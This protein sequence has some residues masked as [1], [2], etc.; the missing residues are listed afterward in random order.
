M[1]AR[2]SPPSRSLRI[3]ILLGP[4]GGR[5]VSRLPPAALI[6]RMRKP[7]TGSLTKAQPVTH[8]CQAL[9]GLDR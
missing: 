5:D 1:I 7:A 8:D 9:F 6:E 3:R 2:I 4:R